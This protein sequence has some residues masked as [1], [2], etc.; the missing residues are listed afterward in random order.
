MASFRLNFMAAWGK[1]S[2]ETWIT[3]NKEKI[4]CSE[5]KMKTTDTFNYL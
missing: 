4:F 2:S 1:N 3:E 5:Q